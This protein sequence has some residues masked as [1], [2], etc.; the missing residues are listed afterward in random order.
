VEVEAL[1]RVDCVVQIYRACSMLFVGARFF[2]GIVVVIVDGI[3]VFFMLCH[4][5]ASAGV[6]TRRKQHSCVQ[7][8]SFYLHYTLCLMQL[9]VVR[10]L[11]LV[12]CSDNI[13]MG[14]L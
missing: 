3:V 2:C 9:S 1:L 4:T 13:P 10:N 12:G 14:G 5:L 6:L 11:I 7:G 8:H